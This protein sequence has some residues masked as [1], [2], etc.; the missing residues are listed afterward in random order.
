MTT[1]L[2]YSDFTDSMLAPPL[3]VPIE[4]MPGI[5]W[6]RL[7]LPFALNHVNIY[8]IDD[9]E[10]WA[11]L[12]TGLGDQETQD[13]WKTLLADHID[14]PLTRLI[15]THFH[16]D[17][18]GMAG[19][20]AAQFDLPVHMSETEYLL[21]RNIHLD[22]GAL[23]AEHYRRFY[24]RHGLDAETTQRVVT[25][26]H[27]YLRF[28]TGLPPTFERLVDGD[29]LTLGG[30]DFQVITGG[31]HSPEQV[32][33]YCAAERIFFS[34]DQVLSKISPNVSVTATIPNGNPLNDYLRSLAALGEIIPADALVLPGHGLPF[35]NAPS[36]IKE[37]TAHHQARCDQILAACVTEPRSVAELVPLLFH[38]PLDP[39]QT[40]FAFSEIL[41]HVNLML[42]KGQIETAD[43]AP[44]LV[45]YVPRAVPENRV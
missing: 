45:R 19:W 14:R 23:D 43:T 20:L 44:G 26:G 27:A 15:V 28:V 31:G 39:Q 34:A 42:R 11:V 2:V 17:H 16:P 33:L 41:A 38:R 6:I 12:D 10:G 13:V 32:V 21:S 40:S 5:V 36:R 3:G 24:L 22:P 30:R 8:L 25:Q 18:I 4:V 35:H 1:R 7:A 9:G 37:L 29:R